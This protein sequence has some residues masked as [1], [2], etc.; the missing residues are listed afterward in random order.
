MNNFFLG[1][2]SFASTYVKDLILLLNC[3]KSSALFIEQA[4]DQS[5][6]QMSYLFLLAFIFIRLFDCDKNLE[7]IIVPVMYE[8]T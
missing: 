8:T 5:K 3:D 2:G 6:A 4:I 7:G 1:L